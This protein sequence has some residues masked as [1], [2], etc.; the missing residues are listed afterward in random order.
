LAL[1]YR[2]IRAHSVESL[3]ATPVQRLVEYSSPDQGTPQLPT[4][5]SGKG[6][7]ITRSAAGE[8]I[9]ILL[10]FLLYQ[11]LTTAWIPLESWPSTCS[12]TGSPISIRD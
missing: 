10:M 4:C 9:L 1:T 7:H 11:A 12:Y 6:L 8:R 3:D 2:R 5:I